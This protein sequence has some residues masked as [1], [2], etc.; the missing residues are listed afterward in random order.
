MDDDTTL[1]FWLIPSWEENWKSELYQQELH[2]FE[3]YAAS[4]DLRVLPASQLLK[5]VKDVIAYE[6]RCEELLSHGKYSLSFGAPSPLSG[7]FVITL[8]K[9]LGSLG[10]GGIIGAWI[11]AKHGRK[12]RLKVGDIEAEAQTPEEVERLVARALEIQQ[13]NQPKVVRES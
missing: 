6:T 3:R 8:A 11:Q 10:L 5:S 13:R 1:S 4:K 2:E 12:V 9:T 7:E